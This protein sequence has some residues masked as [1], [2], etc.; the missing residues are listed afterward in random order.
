M[1]KL[2]T[3]CPPEKPKARHVVKKIWLEK[4]RPKKISNI[5]GQE[6]VKLMMKKSVE[7]GSLPHLLFHGPSGTGKTSTILALCK[8]LFGQ[9]LFKE[10]VFMLNA[11]DERGIDVVRNKIITLSKISINTSHHKNNKDSNKIIPCYKL[12]ILDEADAMTKD[13]QYALRKV[14]ET[15]VGITRFCF[16]CNYRNKIIE[17]IAS[18]CTNI[19][20][21]QLRFSESLERLKMIARKEKIEISKDHLEILINKSNGDMRKSISFLQNI[22]YRYKFKKSISDKDITDVCAIIPKDV[23][24]KISNACLG[25]KMSIDQIV[26]LARE[27]YFCS[28]VSID[29]IDLLKDKVIEN[30]SIKDVTKAVILL[31]IGEV[32]NNIINGSDEYIQ[33]MNIFT[34]INNCVNE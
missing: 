14:M 34:Q 5:V 26:S 3:E 30:D 7:T 10:R 32:E 8:E 28:Y 27:I 33:M 15:Y 18:R 1:L 19:R 25:G 9:K 13:A 24:T 22:K 23:I 6:T 17:A 20:F 21:N 29:I 12:I 11:S 16:I 31:K 4:Y 2:R